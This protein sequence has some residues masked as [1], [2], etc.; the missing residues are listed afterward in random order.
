MCFTT[1][2]SFTSRSLFLLLHLYHQTKRK[3]MSEKFRVCFCCSRSFKVRASEPPEDIQRLFREYSDNGSMSADHLLRFVNQVQG[4]GQAGLDYA[5]EVFHRLKHHDVF[6][7]HHRG[8]HL[9]GFYRYL[10]HD[11]NSPLPL[12]RHVHHDMTAPMSHYF[13]YTGHNSYLT[14]NQLNSR[15]SSEPIAEALRRGVRVIELD[16]WPDPSGNGVDVRHGGTLTSHEDL[17]KCLNAIKEN[18]F[19]TSEYPVVITF[20]DHLT[21]NLQRK[22]VKMVRKTFKGTLFRCGQENPMCFPSPEALK[23]KILISTKPPKEYMQSQ[24]VQSTT[25]PWGDKAAGPIQEEDEESAAVEYRDLITI[26]A[27]KRGDLK[28]CLS[29]DPSRA[30]RISMSELWLETLVKTRAT[31]LVRFTQKNMLRIFPKTTRI[32]SSNYDPLVGWTHGAQMVA[33]NM[34]GYGK[35]LW[36]MQGMFR[37]NG[38]CGYLKKPDILLSTGP[39]GEVF[40]PRQPLHVKTTL[41]VKIY[42]GEGWSLDFPR[43]HFDQYSPP[44][45]FV[46]IG[47]AGVPRDTV[48]YRT[49][50]EIDEWFP[51]W[52]QEFLFQLTVPELGLLWIIVQDYDSNTQ[53]DFAGQICLPLS[54]L[55][56]GF[57]SVRLHDRSGKAYDHARLLVRFAFDPPQAFQIP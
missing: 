46:K 38:G 22:V 48:S 43:H 30:I 56:S 41:K 16:L 34:Q 15:S 2:P 21:R 24:T 39:G 45:F 25:A 33:F 7:L 20:E 47:I 23:K 57:R 3:T 54:E 1:P 40:D 19:D 12:S 35:H 8:L 55:R 26:H 42:T 31:D 37:A 53:N 32:D 50:T 51:V 6:H 52:N 29:G 14:G 17:Q 49:E 44:D 27:C 36:I 13:I 18:A 28:S 10:L 4:E 9:R 11:V 5:T